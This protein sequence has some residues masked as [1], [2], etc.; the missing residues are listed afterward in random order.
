M[1][2]VNLIRVAAVAVCCLV[3]SCNLF[4]ATVEIHEPDAQQTDTAPTFPEHDDG[5]PPPPDSGVP[6]ADASPPPPDTGIDAA[7]DVPEPEPEPEPQFEP[8]RRILFIGNSFTLGGPI[9]TLVDQLANDA[10]WPDPEVVMAAV[11]GESLEGHSGR[12]T[13][14]ARVDEGN[15][16]VVVLQEYSTR[17]TDSLGNPQ[18]FKQYAA[19]FHDR[20]KASSPNARVILYQTWARHPSHSF[21]PGSFPNP[22]AMQLQ[23]RTHYSDAAHRA[24]PALAT[25]AATPRVEVAPVGDAWELHLSRSDAVRLHGSDNYHAGTNGEY[26]NA[27]V[28]YSTIYRRSVDGLTSLGRGAGAAL[29]RDADA[30]TGWTTRGGPDA[31]MPTLGL[32]P[33]QTVRLDFGGVSPGDGWT[34]ISHPRQFAENVVDTTNQ[35]TSVDVAVTRLFQGTNGN[36]V[37]MNDFGWPT[38]AAGD[39]LFCG[40]FGT[41]ADGLANPARVEVAGLRPGR[42]YDVRLFAG[43]EGADPGFGRLTRYT[44]TGAT[45]GSADLEVTDNRTDAVDFEVTATAAGTF[46]LDVAVSPAGTS[47]FCYLGVMEITGR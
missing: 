18:N 44:V 41:H 3:A 32:A 38:E 29:R 28:L 13:T 5:V 11:G 2:D 45:T 22:A 43:R 33:N 47:R 16:D 20:I 37:T 17:P 14:T 6:H 35:R 4:E 21:Y 26:L 34:T 9:P 42:T 23:L 27:L 10:G 46:T 36:G 31:D 15:W 7:P 39:T 1:K 40:S 24:I 19:W 30:A 12:A 25:Q 8:P